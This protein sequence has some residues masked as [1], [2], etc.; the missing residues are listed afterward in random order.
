MRV[1]AMSPS[2]KLI[3]L[4]QFFSSEPEFME[5]LELADSVT[6]TLKTL[7]RHPQDVDFIARKKG[8]TYYLGFKGKNRKYVLT[9]ELGD[10]L[11]L[12]GLS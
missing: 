4:D 9:F 5:N 7:L 11:L 2:H 3:S 12:L 1:L 8:S 10:D 6:R